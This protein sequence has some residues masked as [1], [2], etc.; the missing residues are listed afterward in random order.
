MVTQ[1]EIKKLFWKEVKKTRNRKNNRCANNKD[2]TGKTLL[3]N[4]NARKENDRLNEGKSNMMTL[5]KDGTVYYVIRGTLLK[6][7]QSFKY[8]E[9]VVKRK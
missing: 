6:Q 5:C 8:Y 1:I 7:V 4:A 2:S 3:D 9:C